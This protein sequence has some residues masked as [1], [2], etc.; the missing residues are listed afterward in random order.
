MVATPEIIPTDLTLEIGDDVSPDRFIAAA[1][2]FFGYV[3]EIAKALSPEGEAPHWRV[4]VREGSGLLGMQPTLDTPDDVL[5]PIYARTQE[6]LA[7]LSRGEAIET[8]PLP[9][10]ALRH[11]KVLSGLSE[12]VDGRPTPIRVWVQRKPVEIGPSIARAI[13]EDWRAD[14]NDYGTIEGRL[15]TIQDHEGSLRLQIRDGLFRQNVRAYFDEAK[16]P[17]AFNA[18]RKRVEVSGIV[19][20][21]KNG[22]PISI[23]VTQIDELPDDKD[24]PTAADVRGLFKVAE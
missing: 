14:Y 10:P 24:L 16:L 6:G 9:E 8:V 22:T 13:E 1:R 5:A 11:A 17:L 2:A 4:L 18:F 3:S 19:H 12:G 23:E 7:A 15:E 21:R 20:Y